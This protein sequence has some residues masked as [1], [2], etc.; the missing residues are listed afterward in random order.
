MICPCC[1]KNLKTLSG[2]W[3][4]GQKTDN[5]CRLCELVLNKELKRYAETGLI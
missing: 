5:V 4:D 3:F 1:K 2:E